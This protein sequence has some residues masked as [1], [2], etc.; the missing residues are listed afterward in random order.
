MAALAADLGVRRT[1]QTMSHDEPTRATVPQPGL[2]VLWALSFILPGMW[3]LGLVLFAA[4]LTPWPALNHAGWRY[5]GPVLLITFAGH[6]AIVGHAYVSSHFDSRMKREFYRRLQF[7]G[8]AYSFWRQR[9]A[10][11]RRDRGSH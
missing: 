6:M 11:S 5:G 9:V 3:I 8:G 4:T 7:T 10:A 2:R 1:D